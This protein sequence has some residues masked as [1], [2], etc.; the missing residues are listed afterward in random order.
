MSPLVVYLLSDLSRGI[1]GQVIRLWGGNLHLMGHPSTVSPLE[2]ESWS[3][4]NLDA[5][6]RGPLRESFQPFGR[7]MPRYAWLGPV[8][9]E[10]PA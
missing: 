2:R 5:A 6:F 7:D 3:V 8:G 4:E 10:P 1:T 9:S